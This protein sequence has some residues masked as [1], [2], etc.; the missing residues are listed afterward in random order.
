MCGICGFLNFGQGRPDAAVVAKM[1]ATMGHRG[2][3]DRGVYCV[4]RLG[5]GHARLSIIDLGGGHQPMRNADGSL[6]ITFNGEIFNYI[7]LKKELERKGHYFATTSDTEVILHWYEE[8]GEECVRRFNGQWA[9]AIWDNRKHRLFLSRDR[10]GVR[11]LYYAQVNGCFVFA[12]EVKALLEFPGVERQIDWIG[13]DQL[14][15]L[16]CPIPPRTV[17]KDIQQ[18]PP[19]HSMRVDEMGL[20]SRAYWQLDYG[21]GYTDLSETDASERLLELLTDATRIRLRSDVPVGSYLSGGLDSTVVTSIIRKCTDTPLKTFSISFEHP[22][23]DEREHQQEAV[24]HLDTEH[25]EIRISSRDIVR[26]FPGVIRHTESPVLRSAPAPMYLLSR[27]VRELGYKVVLS[28]EGSDEILGGYDIF[29]EAKIRRFWAQQPD[30]RLRPL[31]LRRLYPYLKDLHA[32]P[33]EYLKAFF[34]IEEKQ[35]R[36]PLSSHLPRWELTARIKAFLSADAKA[37]IGAYDVLEEVRSLM[38]VGFAHWDW[39]ARAQYLESRFLLPGYILSSQGDRVGMAH[40]VEGR[41]PFLDYRVVEFAAKLQPAL[42]IKVLNEKYI[43]KQAARELIPA[44][45][46]IRK[47]Q[48]YRAPD[49]DAFFPD[50]ESA[51]PYVEQ[52]FDPE[53]LRKDGVFHARAVEKLRAKVRNGSAAGVKD[54]MAV[55]AILS[56]QLWISD[57][58]KREGQNPPTRKEPDH[59]AI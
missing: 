48:P 59:A 50:G 47:K 20:R 26:A 28:G 45:A 43:L 25:G 1:V 54:N 9:F 32:Q 3:D 51:E 29:K 34:H 37:Q 55:T 24:R 23:F 42:K 36:D 18:L 19:G 30:S 27:L 2:P 52:E 56:T 53:R 57:F 12:S 40:S 6:W 16:W 5:L 8:E 35:M 7:E 33:V 4:D 31:L 58:L 10:L 15:T 11:P 49:I 22:E 46:R 38:P 21:S 14:F 39:L 41:F 44:N 17:F 13:L